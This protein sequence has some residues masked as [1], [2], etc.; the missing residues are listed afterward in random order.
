MNGALTRR[1]MLRMGSALGLGGM[2]AGPPRT[3]GMVPMPSSEPP[4][5]DPQTYV[6]SLTE[7]IARLVL[8]KREDRDTVIARLRQDGL[9]ADIAALRSVSRVIKVKLQLARDE[10][11]SLTL[12]KLCERAGYG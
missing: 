1:G 2:F 7:K 6:P 10:Q 5:N 9:D 8:R 4:S 3:A 11:K 12:R